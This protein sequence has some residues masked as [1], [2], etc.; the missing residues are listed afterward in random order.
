MFPRLAH[1]DSTPSSTHTQDLFRLVRTEGDHARILRGTAHVARVWKASPELRAVNDPRSR[2]DT[3]QE[4]GSTSVDIQRALSQLHLA[5]GTP[6]VLRLPTVP[7]FGTEAG[8][9]MWNWG[10]IAVAIICVWPEPLLADCASGCTCR[11]GDRLFQE[12]SNFEVSSHLS[13]NEH[14]KL[15]EECEHVRADLQ[16]LWFRDRDHGPWLPKCRIVVHRTGEAYNRALGLVNDTSVGCTT[17]K[18]DGERVVLRHVD[19]RADASEWR[20]STLRHELTHV[21]VADQVNR[22]TVL[23]WADEGMAALAEDEP[24]QA[25]RRKAAQDARSRGK[26]YSAREL[27]ELRTSPHPDY[28]HAFYGQSVSLAQFL[29]LRSGH[30]DFIRFLDISA[31]KS[32]Q[33][34]LGDVYGIA[35]AEQL[36]RLWTAWGK[37]EGDHG[38]NKA[39]GTD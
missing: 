14:R 15:V 17:L 5:G 30:E 29:V 8:A 12:S 18:V 32:Q 36:D 22:A 1:P 31:T 21:V 3:N 23:P 16:N 37:S 2:G 34:A 39:G 7:P 13:D 38:T 11:R 4:T 10:S 33:A 24:L 27:L 25:R 26:V 19:L 35:D 28:R 20:T 6:F 9:A